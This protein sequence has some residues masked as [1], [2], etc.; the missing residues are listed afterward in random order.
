MLRESYA[1]C[2]L[3]DVPEIVEV[4]RSLRELAKRSAVKTSNTQSLILRQLQ[5]TVLT[6]VAL[7]LNNRSGLAAV[8]SGNGGAK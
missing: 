4:I 8:L 1:S 5:P 2:T 7:E 3:A 6:A